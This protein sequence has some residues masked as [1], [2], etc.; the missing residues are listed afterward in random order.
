MTHRLTPLTTL[1]LVALLLSGCAGKQ[2]FLRG[3]DQLAANQW[4]PAL[5][6][7]RQ[8]SLQAPRNAEYRTAI[9]STS[10]RAVA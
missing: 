5:A 2:A 10:E 1:G 8:A 7:F 6:S 4:E 3:Q 9:S